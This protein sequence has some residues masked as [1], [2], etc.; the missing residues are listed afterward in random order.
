MTN[1][2]VKYLWKEYKEF[3]PIYIIRMTSRIGNRWT[4]NECLQLQ[5]E[6]ELL[7]LSIDEIA[8]RHS[9]TPNAIMFKLDQEG[10][11]DYNTLYHKFMQVPATFQIQMEPPIQMEQENT[12]NSYDSNED[13]RKQIKRMKKQISALTKM[14]AQQNTNTSTSSSSMNAFLC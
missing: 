12:T 13:L 8:A 10:F 14:F 3:T 6:Y 5:R 9:R 2:D 1:K 11:A 4:V 7:E